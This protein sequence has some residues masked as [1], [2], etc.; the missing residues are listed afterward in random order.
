MKT[1]SFFSTPVAEKSQ[2]E[3]FEEAS[4]RNALERMGASGGR[5]RPQQ[6]ASRPASDPMQGKRRR[7]VKDGDVQVEKHSLARTTP[8]TLAVPKTFSTS[9][10]VHFSDEENGEVSKIRRQLADEK[11]HAEEV[12]RQLEALQQTCKSMETRQVHADLMVRELKA[13]LL[14]RDAE[15]SEQARAL[16]SVQ[17][18]LAQKE[19]EAQELLKKLEAKPRGRPRIRSLEEPKDIELVEVEDLEDGEP[20]PVKWWKD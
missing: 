3:A 18:E 15:L 6:S 11:L 10:A 14:E 12:E 20:Q 5:A 16:R 13:K 8:R 9:R 19:E 17:R 2:D 7:F 1:P 4:L